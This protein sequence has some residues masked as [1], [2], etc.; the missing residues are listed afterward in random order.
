MAQRSL[1][2]KVLGVEGIKPLP[3]PSR[4]SSRILSPKVPRFHGQHSPPEAAGPL[5]PV[6]V[7]ALT[8][9]DDRLAMVPPE[10]KLRQEDEWLDPRSRAPAHPGL[11]ARPSLDL[12]ALLEASPLQLQAPP[13]ARLWNHPGPEHRHDGV[14]LGWSPSICVPERPREGFATICPSLSIAQ[15]G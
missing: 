4:L 5:C 13:A 6:S 9:L 8:S 2:P 7:T 11:A 14:G 12:S 3:H 10:P 15:P 1:P